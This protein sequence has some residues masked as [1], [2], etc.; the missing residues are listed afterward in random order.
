MGGWKELNAEGR[1]AWDQ[2]QQAL[3]PTKRN[4]LFT[5]HINHHFN[6]NLSSRAQSNHLQLH[7]NHWLFLVL[8]F[9]YLL[10]KSYRMNIYNTYA[11]LALFVSSFF[12]SPQKKATLMSKNGTWLWH[13]DIPYNKAISYHQY[14]LE[15]IYMCQK[16]DMTCP[17]ILQQ[18]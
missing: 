6:F 16:Q 1:H 8:L 18:L 13:T 3:P 12:W 14:P 15:I 11:V 17:E 10:G 9:K 7:I 2:I 5:L 4:G